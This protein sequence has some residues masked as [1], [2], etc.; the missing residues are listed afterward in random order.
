MSDLIEGRDYVI[1]N[2]FTV[3]TSRFLWERGH[4]CGNGC[5]NC[6][7]SFPND[8]KVVSLVPSWTDTLVCCS[9]DVIGRTR[10]CVHPAEQV[11][12]IPKVGGTKQCDFERINGLDPDLV[13]LDKEENAKEL[14]DPLDAPGQSHQV[15]L[16]LAGSDA[17]ALSLLLGDSKSNFVR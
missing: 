4:C 16:I 3:F 15:L 2:G 6:P 7:Y 5:R 17:S 13:V 9:V 12:S 11:Q 10:F 1:E 14:L 8:K